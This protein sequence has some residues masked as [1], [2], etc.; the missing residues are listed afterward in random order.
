MN[1]S[2]LGKHAVCHHHI[3]FSV[4]LVR[5]RI[6]HMWGAEGGASIVPI[7]AQEMGFTEQTWRQWGRQQVE[8]TFHVY[9]H[10]DHKS[11]WK[12]GF[13]IATC[14]L[15]LF[16]HITNPSM[17]IGQSPAGPPA[18]P[19]ARPPATKLGLLHLRACTGT[20]VCYTCPPYFTVST[21][22]S[23]GIVSACHMNALHSLL[24]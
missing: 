18:D 6:C 21:V 5:V 14:P 7:F 8:A 23:L 22:C 16:M 13:A 2:Q 19:P 24:C 1:S 12:Q 3:L 15:L 4:T 9:I 20:H 17:H 11:R 10:M